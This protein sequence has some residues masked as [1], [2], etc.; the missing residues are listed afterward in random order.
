MEN[1]AQMTIP[2]FFTM[3]ETYK[4]KYYETELTLVRYGTTN[5]P[6]CAYFLAIT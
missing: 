1:F 4:I 2:C 3:A 6:F 5:S